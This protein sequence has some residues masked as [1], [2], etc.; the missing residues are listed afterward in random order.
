MAH[1]GNR[2]WLRRPYSS[3]QELQWQFQI[4]PALVG[5]A[6]GMAEV[7][8]AADG[9][10]AVGAVAVGAGAASALASEPACF[11]LLLLV[12]LTTAAT[13]TP[14]P[15]TMATPLLTAMALM[16]MGTVTMAM[17]ATTRAIGTPALTPIVVITIGMVATTQIVGTP[18]VENR[19]AL[20]HHRK[21]AVK[22]VF[23]FSAYNTFL[24]WTTVQLLAARSVVNFCNS[25]CHFRWLDDDQC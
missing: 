1:Y 21:T 3:S 5:A 20:A 15:I 16:A 11:S 19:A 4:R 2:L 25:C 17:A 9:A 13:A 10:V 22:A 23:L 6:A 18:T 8:T 12:L 14:T 7:G 24:R